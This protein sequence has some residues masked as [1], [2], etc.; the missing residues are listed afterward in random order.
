MVV[1]VVVTSLIFKTSSVLVH[2]AGHRLFRPPP[3][4][5]RPRDHATPAPHSSPR[6]SRRKKGRSRRTRRAGGVGRCPLG[7]GFLGSRERGGSPGRQWFPSFSGYTTPVK[8]RKKKSYKKT[9]KK[10]KKRARQAGLE[11]G[12]QKKGTYSR[13]V[14]MCLI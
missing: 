6:C 2:P 11:L 12:I 13:R 14:R 5:P 3:D 4:P 8:K 7:D 1:V 10:K 9:K